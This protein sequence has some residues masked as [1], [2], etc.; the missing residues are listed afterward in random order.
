MNKKQ[1]V[2]K[3]S[4]DQLHQ[5]DYNMKKLFEGLD[6]MD[7]VN[8]IEPNVSVDEYVAKMGDDKDIVTITFTVKSEL[9]GNDLVEWF[10]RGYDFILDASVS[11]GESKFG[12]WLVFVEI[13][14]KNS[15][16]S[17]LIEMLKDL[18]TL[19]NL[20]LD[21]WEIKVDGKMYKPNVDTLKQVVILSP[22]QYKNIKDKELNE[23]RMVANLDMKNNY[24]NDKMIKDMKAIAG[25]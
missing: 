20:H 8:Q 25:L 10:E 23:M 7:M 12:K 18:E 6:Y 16:P 21:D 15:V 9:V 4:Q 19:T 13:E 2:D 14:R 11:S 24:N 3:C 17:Q 5:W 22:Y 1:L